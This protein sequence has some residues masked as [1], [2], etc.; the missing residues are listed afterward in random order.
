MIGRSGAPPR[1]VPLFGHPGWHLC[2]P[3]GWCQEA[4]VT[5]LGLEPGV[6]ILLRHAQ[7]E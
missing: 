7:A 6:E 2:L 4:Q 3:S 5:V 1:W